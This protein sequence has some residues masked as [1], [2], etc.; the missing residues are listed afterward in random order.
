MGAKQA[1][2]DD[3]TRRGEGRGVE[4]GVG[5]AMGCWEKVGEVGKNRGS[6]DRSEKSDGVVVRGLRR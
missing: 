4:G 3:F 2:G 1:Q 6:W 5:R